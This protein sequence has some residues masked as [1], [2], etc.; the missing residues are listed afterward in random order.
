M[1]KKVE[2]R[3]VEKVQTLRSY[4]EEKGRKVEKV[5][6]MKSYF[7][8]KGGQLCYSILTIPILW[9]KTNDHCYALKQ[10]MPPHPSLPG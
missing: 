8:E 5:Q 3:K 6:T 10:A 9:E 7:E 4:F 1:K 2:S